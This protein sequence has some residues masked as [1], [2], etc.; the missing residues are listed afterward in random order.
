[1]A[2]RRRA[3]SRLCARHVA[4]SLAPGV[5]GHLGEYSHNRCFGVQEGDASCSAFLCIK[6]QPTLLLWF[7]T[8]DMSDPLPLAL[9]KLITNDALCSKLC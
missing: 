2:A 1:M 9:T 7:S 8:Q 4:S 3:K 5:G 6:I